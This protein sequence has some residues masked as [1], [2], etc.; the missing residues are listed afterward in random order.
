[1]KISEL[2]KVLEACKAEHG[3]KEIRTFSPEGFRPISEVTPGLSFDGEDYL[4]IEYVRNWP[5]KTGEPSGRG[6]DNA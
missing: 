1:M 3:D 2:V 6:R 4:I 5:S